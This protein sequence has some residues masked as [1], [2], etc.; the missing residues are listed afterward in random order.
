MIREIRQTHGQ[1]HI[2]GSV[3]LLE[4]FN[5]L[6]IKKGQNFK[7]FIP[8]LSDSLKIYE[9]LVRQSHKTKKI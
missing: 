2:M 1:G 9:K 6:A 3:R 5:A 4:E 7:E 8:N